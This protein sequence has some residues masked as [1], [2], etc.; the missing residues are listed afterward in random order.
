MC[1]WKG[2]MQEPGLSC[3]RD[4]YPPI[5]FWQDQH[6]EEQFIRMVQSTENGGAGSLFGVQ[7][8]RYDAEGKPPVSTNNRRSA[9]EIN[10]PGRKTI[11]ETGDVTSTLSTVRIDFANMPNYPDDGLT[12]NPCWPRTV[13]DDPGFALLADD[14]WYA[15][16]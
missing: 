5:V 15:G 8:C 6:F 4:E 3:Q 2:Y 13:T 16:K 7:F 10:G 9:R 11:I 14:P 1:R 12:Q